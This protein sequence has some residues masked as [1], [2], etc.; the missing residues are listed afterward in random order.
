[1]NIKEFGG[2]FFR[3]PREVLGWGVGIQFSSY[4]LGLLKLLGNESVIWFCLNY[5]EFWMKFTLFVN[6]WFCLWSQFLHDAYVFMYVCSCLVEFVGMVTM[7]FTSFLV[8]FLFAISMYYALIWWYTCYWCPF[9]VLHGVDCCC[10]EVQGGCTWWGGGGGH[11]E[12]EY[13]PPSLE[14]FLLDFLFPL[15][16]VFCIL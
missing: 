9:F 8:E 3:N 6:V 16:V 14:F 11:E 10:D 15:F 13:G 7:I 1:M 2:I 4:D 5:S 12:G